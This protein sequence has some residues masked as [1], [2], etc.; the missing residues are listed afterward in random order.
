MSDKRGGLKQSYSLSFFLI[1]ESRL[2]LARGK[3]GLRAS[4]LLQAA[5]KKQIQ[6]LSSLAFVERRENVIFL[7][8]SGVG[9]THLAI[10]FG[11]AAIQGGYK[12]RFVTAADLIV[13]MGGTSSGPTRGIPQARDSG[14]ESADHR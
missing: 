1:A 9:K 3:S 10:A 8:P 5:P 14:T 11:Y 2:F 4:A 7:G 12:T 13:Q 6:A